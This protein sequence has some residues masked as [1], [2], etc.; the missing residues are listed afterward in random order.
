MTSPTRK[1][2]WKMFD[3]ISAT[4]DKVN[5]VVSFGMDLRWRK[6]L[7]QHLPKKKHLDILDL[8]TGTGDQAIQIMRSKA[9]IKSI[10][11]IDLSKEMLNLAKIKIPEMKIICADAEKLPFAKESFDAASFSFGIR[12]VPTPLNALNEIYRVLKPKGRCLILE[13]SM[14]PWPIKS[15]YLFY[16]R[17]ILPKIGGFL[18]KDQA[19]YRY[20]N[21]TIEEFPSGPNFCK[22]MKRAGF[23][24]IQAVPM[25]LGSVTLYIGEKH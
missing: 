1:D 7:A 18:S 4:Y 13:F 6:K 15:F 17:H 19:A 3:R 25:N 2:V 11:G 10:T 16:L 22:I 20:L 5:R 23:S 21:E 8:A 9:S 14:P 24:R 12:N